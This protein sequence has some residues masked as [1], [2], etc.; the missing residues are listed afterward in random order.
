MREKFKMLFLSSDRHPAKRVDVHVLFA[1]KLSGRGHRV[2]FVLQSEEEC[3]RA[4]ETDWFG[5]RVFVGRMDNGET[6]LARAK[7]HAYSILH[8]IV[9]AWKM[10]REGYDFIQLKDKYIS[11]LF[12][13]PMARIVGARF[14]YWLSFPFPEE[15]FFKARTRNSRYPLFYWLRGLAFDFI[16]YRIIAKKADF[17]FVQ[18][19][20]MKRDLIIRGVSDRKLMP[21]PMGVALERVDRYLSALHDEENQESTPIVLYLGTLARVRKMDFMIRVFARVL[22][23]VPEAKLHLVGGGDDEEDIEILKREAARLNVTDQVVITGWL[24]MDGAM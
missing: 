24:P 10:R 19:E 2:D 4:Y 23:V 5:C 20:Q 3:S 11:A 16:F 1:E 18:S 13:V 8:D 22:E 17:I 7:K 12:L 14:L 21:V 15:S 9:T 6:R